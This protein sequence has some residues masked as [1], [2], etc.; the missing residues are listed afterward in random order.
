MVHPV[1]ALSAG[2]P[3]A[4]FVLW[5]CPPV[6]EP[7]KGRAEERGAALGLH[8][9][10]LRPLLPAPQHGLPCL[11]WRLRLGFQPCFCCG[12]AG[13][14]WGLCLLESEKEMIFLLGFPKGKENV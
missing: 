9:S 5:V 4:D 12:P 1:V 3:A 8:L 6:L 7:R 10:P 2:P 11:C 13:D 14:L